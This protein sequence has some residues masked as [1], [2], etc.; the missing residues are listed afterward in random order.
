[1]LALRFWKELYNGFLVFR[2]Q[3]FNPSP[4]KTRVPVGWA[5]VLEAGPALQ[6]P[7]KAVTQVQGAQNSQ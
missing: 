1:M 4:A 7:H 5:C 2:W 3:L 6:P